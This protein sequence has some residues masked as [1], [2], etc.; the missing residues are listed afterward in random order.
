MLILSF[1]SSDD[2]SILRN[3]IEIFNSDLKLLRDSN[4][5]S[6]EENRQE[7]RHASIVFAVDNAEQAQK[8]IKKKLYI[9]ELQLVAESYKSAETKTQ[10]QKCQKLEHSIKHCINQEC[11]QI[12]A[13]KHYTKHHKCHICQIVEIEC[14]HSKLKCRN[15]GGNHK[16]NNQICS[17][18]EK[19]ASLS[20]SSVKSDVAMKNSADFAV[21]ISHVK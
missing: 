18:W 19:Q 3:E 5:L 16:S 14:S 10:C 2:L 7:K 21:I 4:W 9:T 13:E 15:C 8:A 11:C 6:S 1:S 20:V 17:I 12:C